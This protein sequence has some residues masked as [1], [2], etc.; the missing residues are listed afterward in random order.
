MELVT[1]QLM[2][3]IQESRKIAF[4]N[5]AQAFELAHK[6]KLIAVENNQKSSQAAALFAMGLACRSMTDL[7]QC[8][9]HAYDSYQLYEQLGNNRGIAEALNLLG[10]VYFY[11][12]QYD[13]ALEYFLNALFHVKGL[14]EHLIMSRI[15]NNIGEVY[16]EASNEEE[17][18]A[19]Y[20][21]A[22]EISRE[23]QFEMNLPIILENIGEIHFKNLNL[24]ISY[25]YFQK[26]YDMLIELDDTPSLA[27]VENKIGKIHFIKKDY[28][29]AKQFYDSA[30]KR[31][32]HIGNKFY[33]IDVFVNLAEME[34]GENESSFLAYLNQAVQHA[35]QVQA[36]KKLSSLYTMLTQFHEEK[37][38]YQLALDYY[39]R[40]HIVEQAIDT[41]VISK[42]LEI[43]K[44]ELN[45]GFTGKEVEQISKM[46]EQL[47][48][49]I[50]TQKKLLAELETANVNL[51]DEVDYD[52]LT[53]VASRRGVTRYLQKIWDEETLLD[54][55]ISLMMLDIDY[56]KRYNDYHGHVQG[57]E[58]LKL[59]AE[60]MKLTFGNQQGILG[61]YGGEE[62]VCFTNGLEVTPLKQFAES[63]RKAVGDLNLSY[64]FKGETLPVTISI[65]T[66]HCKRSQVSQVLDMYVMADNELY[67]AKNNGRNR[68]EISVL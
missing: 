11:Y 54:Q 49:E 26:S 20:E 43:I 16:R 64:Q 51:S 36:R 67:R 32:E 30:L 28:K 47:E 24:D 4:R 5:P 19:A 40:Y 6:A 1:E 23:H 13:Q 45:K 2:D 18:L 35:E 10:V 15:Y 68:V 53:G 37:G 48:I 8:Y 59:V 12:A 38:H 55:P 66:V 25:D 50:A 65:G 7:E 33:T 39:K 27:E 61:R 17:A 62:F 52:E 57:D 60:C 46:N 63:I 29:K 3:L 21:Q 22:L 41:Q 31:L 58:C 56:F 34:R 14:E 9:D 44:I 42:K